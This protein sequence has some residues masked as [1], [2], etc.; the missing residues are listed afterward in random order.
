[1]FL[2]PSGTFLRRAVYTRSAPHLCKAVRQAIARTLV[3]LL[4]V[5]GSHPTTAFQRDSVAVAPTQVVGYIFA[6]NGTSPIP[7]AVVALTQFESGRAFQTVTD[8]RGKYSLPNVPPGH[9]RVDVRRIGFRPTYVTL[10]IASARPVNL[11]IALDVHPILLTPLAVTARSHPH[12]M[13]PTTRRADAQAITILARQRKYLTPDVR[14]ITA[15]DV[16]QA[17]TFGDGDV[18]RALQ[19]VP[20]VTTKSDWTAELWTRGGQ[21]DQTRVYFDGVPVFNPLHTFG[22]FSAISAEAIERVRIH[23]GVKLSS[24]DEG[25]AGVVEIVSAS[26]KE[27]DQF[28]GT[29]SFSTFQG[30]ASIRQ[31]LQNGNGGLALSGRIGNTSLRRDSPYGFLD[32]TGRFDLALTAQTSLEASFLWSG[33]R[34]REF[35]APSALAARA[36][37]QNIVGRTTLITMVGKTTVRQTV[38][39]SRASARTQRRT[40]SPGPG[41]PTAITWPTDNSLYQ[42]M[43]R[44]DLASQGSFDLS[45]RAGYEIKLLRTHYYGSP[46][47]PYARQTFTDTLTYLDRAEVKAI[48]G[49]MAWRPF[50]W[51][52]VESGLRIEHGGAPGPPGR[53]FQYAQTLAGSGAVIGPGLQVSQVW[54]MAGPQVPVLQADIITAGGEFWLAPG[55]LAGLNLYQ[56]FSRGVII[57]DPRP[58]FSSTRALFETASNDARGFEA[59]LRKISGP[60]TGD[61]SYAHTKSTMHAL[62][63]TFPSTAER[64]HVINATMHTAFPRPILSGHVSTGVTTRISSGAPFT[65]LLPCPPICS[66]AGAS[67]LPTGPEN[68]AALGGLS[69]GPS[70]FPTNA[71]DDL[72]R[73]RASTEWVGLPNAL[74]AP[75]YW[76]VGASIEWSRSFNATHVTAYMQI[77]NVFNR[78]NAITYVPAGENGC[79]ALSNTTLGSVSGDCFEAGIPFRPVFGMRMRF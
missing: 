5:C 22:M 6:A 54:L 59:S 66:S 27:Q 61:V 37:W 28:I 20:G 7:G 35:D 31:P 11:S 44:G 79:S 16:A 42:I 9:Y 2:V 69:Y 14:E 41:L 64:E 56:R 48:W 38:G 32:F 17:V 60:W 65:R 50:D 3:I 51:I 25:A 71:S 77:R 1:M 19:T 45:W 33:D 57:A 13:K 58:G 53:S 46:T 24:L 34:L 43:F 39:I 12:G 72:P 18:L 75:S 21:W 74:R 10:D 36:D 73:Q 47:A 76:D 68:E 70:Q 29:V 26:A 23:P 15:D 55:L 4:L 62:G 30:G 78:T 40:Q 67:T 8:D 63:A 52:E 49:E